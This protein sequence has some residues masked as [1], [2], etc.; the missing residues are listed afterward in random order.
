M[1][2]V[3]AVSRSISRS[4]GASRT[5]R[6]GRRE[7]LRGAF[8]VGLG[9]TT[10]GCAASP[11]ASP[12]SPTAAAGSSSASSTLMLTLANSEIAVGLNRFALG[13][14]VDGRPLV[15]ADLRFEFFQ[16]NGQSAL[17]R[18]E[19]EAQ[20]RALDSQRGIYV[21]NVVFDA[22]GAWGVQATVS[23]TGQ[24]TQQ[25]RT[26]F[27]VLEQGHA[28]MPGSPAIASR[29][30]TDADVADRREICTAAPPCAMHELSIAEAL[31]RREPL[32]ITFSTPGFCTTQI[33]A[34]VLNEIEQVR[35]R[36]A[37][38]AHFIHVEIYKDPRTLT[39]AEAVQ[40]WGLKSEPWVFV[41][42]RRG[43]IAQ[44]MES[45]TTAE[46]VDA[47]LAAAL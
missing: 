2:S 25:A 31:T 45:I 28:P 29:T 32:V 35:A 4:L 21:A 15:H 16:V 8:A 37:A 26:G 1:S 44:R 30:P 46:E 43:Q 3:N 41:V 6:F 27:Q 34:P 22:A 18:S 19:S 36:R 24:P 5:R 33:C 7:W 38:Q 11:A 14:I 20:Y 10:F 40:E 42:D 47:A 13:V 17:K 12:P 9:S 23:G 39:A